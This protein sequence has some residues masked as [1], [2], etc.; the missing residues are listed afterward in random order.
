MK[1]NQL[2]F[3]I[4]FILFSQP[5]FANCARGGGIFADKSISTST[6][7]LPANVVVESRSYSA[8]EP[9]YDSGWKSGSNSDL[10]I[11]GC[12]RNYVVGFFYL[13]GP[14]VDSPGGTQVMPTN[15][16]GLGVRVTAQNQA[17]P[18]D[19]AMPIDNNW[20]DGDRG[21]D[22]ELRNS[23]YKVELVALG[24]PISSG[25]LSFGSPLA[26]VEFR[27][28]R[29]HT[30]YG[31][32]A[33][34]VALTNTNVTIK[35]MGCNADVSSINFAFG[36]IKMAEFDSTTKIAAPDTQTVTLSCESGT[37]VSLSLNGTPAAGNNANNTVIALTGEGNADVASGI[38][39]QL[40]LQSSGYNSGSNGLPLNQSITLFSSSRNGSTYSSGGTGSQEQLIFSAS[41]FKTGAVVTA[42]SANSSASITLTY[43]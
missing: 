35:A 18:Y 26:Q 29:S 17:G 5:S 31:D 25:Q 20:H 27:E 12:G 4:L 22:H 13:N 30:A 39:V 19:G 10:T 24:G 28:S 11:S 2:F 33:S 7:A 23:Q 38:G 36:S 6:I 42:G 1:I 8:G 16:P 34:N 15:I 37:N 9:L 3:F 43:N 40:G 14:Q 32:V 41:Y 21:S